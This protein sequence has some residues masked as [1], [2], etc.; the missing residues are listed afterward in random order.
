VDLSR[1]CGGAGRRSDEDNAVMKRDGKDVLLQ[2]SS[3]LDN[4]YCG[5]ERGEKYSTRLTA[6]SETNIT[7]V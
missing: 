3:D 1:W 5:A 7:P 4:R 6:T 2:P